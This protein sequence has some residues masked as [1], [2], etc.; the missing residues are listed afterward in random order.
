MQVAAEGWR[1][2]GPKRNR[3]KETGKTEGMGRKGFADCDPHSYSMCS[4]FHFSQQQAGHCRTCQELGLLPRTCTVPPPGY[5][6]EKGGKAQQ[7][8]RLVFQ[9]PDVGV[10][11]RHLKGARADMSLAS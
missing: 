3:N 5:T 4:I 2:Q 8:G 7:Q 1:L 9:H 11:D 6:M 10:N